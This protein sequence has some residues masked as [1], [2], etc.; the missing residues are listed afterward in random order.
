MSPR[1]HSLFKNLLRPLF[2]AVIVCWPAQF[3]A[4]D[5][6]EIKN[7][8]VDVKA[9]TAAKARQQALTQAERRAFYALIS[10]LTLTE[11]Q[12]RIPEFSNAEIASYVRD[13]S[14]AREKASSVRYI[15]RLN[16]RFKPDEIR[17][18]LRS[19]S[20]PFAETPSKPMV[21]LPVYEL[22]AGVVL[23]DEPNPWRQAWSTRD[24]PEGLVPLVV[25]IGDLSDISTV[26]VSEAMAGDPNRLN[27]IAERYGAVS[28][29]VA[30]NNLTIDQATGRQMMTVTLSRPNDPIPVEARTSFYVQ[31]E[32][33]T[34]EAMTVRVTEATAR[35]IENIW[36]RR[37]LIS[38]TGTGVL[39]VTVPIT[40]LKDWL[41]I[42]DQLA[43]VGII[44]RSEIVLMS[45]DQVRVNIHFV[46]GAEQLTTAL[47]Q[48]NLS[49]M[50]ESGEWI[51]MPIGV[52]E[53]PKT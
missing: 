52:F 43:K 30:H 34:I 44:R 6:F 13:F 5:V 8:G 10:R 4:A 35:R 7:I 12:E 47:E 45:R 3:A 18:L 29:V 17:G 49:M 46:G 1:P 21:V 26:G 23:W 33:E 22:G 53:P 31:Q 16:Y 39:A 27:A 36:K 28:S 41:A 48:S 42:R 50:Q 14:V 19:Y 38:Q 2:I 37:N 15:A 51:I 25:P 20:V 9:D 32:N 24:Q 40:G 11:D